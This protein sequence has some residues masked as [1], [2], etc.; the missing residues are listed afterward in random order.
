[1]PYEIPGR[2][3]K[4]AV[5]DIFTFNNKHYLC[6]VDSCNKFLVIKQ[7]E[8][9]RTD[10]PKYRQD[11]ILRILPA[12]Q[13]SLRCGHKL[14]FKEIWELLQATQHISYSVVIVHHS[15]GQ[16]EACIK[17]VKRTMKNTTKQ[18]W[19]YMSFLEI[20]STLINSR[21][22]RPAMLLFNRLSS[23]RLLRFSKPSTG[24]DND[25]PR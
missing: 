8:E 20:R 14:Y 10:N 1:M 2:P 4:S 5:T 16:A 7:A 25:S 15:N 17:F 18:I 23:G 19:I 21:L 9:F 13:N 12:Q 24:C 22:P 3:Y 6:V 11:Y